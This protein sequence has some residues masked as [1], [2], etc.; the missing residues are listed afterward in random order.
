MLMRK[1]KEGYFPTDPIHIYYNQQTWLLRYFLHKTH[2]FFGNNCIG[3]IPSQKL[4]SR[5]VSSNRVISFFSYHSGF[6]FFNN[7]ALKLG[8]IAWHL[9]KILGSV[10]VDTVCLGL[11]HSLLNNG[12]SLQLAEQPKG[13]FVEESHAMQLSEFGTTVLR[14]V[15]QNSC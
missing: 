5:R 1:R 6:I 12:G 15:K 8:T 3:V 14:V 9:F 2:Q 13:E 4:V 7:P 11:D 10:L